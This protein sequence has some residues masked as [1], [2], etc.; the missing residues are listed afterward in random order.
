MFILCNLVLLLSSLSHFPLKLVTGSNDRFIFELLNVNWYV[1]EMINES[2]H[3]SE[4]RMC[5]KFYVSTA[6]TESEA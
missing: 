4:F 3:S 1:N 2:K 5:I 6:P